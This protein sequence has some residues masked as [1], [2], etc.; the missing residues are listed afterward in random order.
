MA[1]EVGSLY[2][3][4]D[5]NDEKLGK[6]L[7]ASDKKVASFGSRLGQLGGQIQQGMKDAAKGLAVV[8]AGL[9]AYAKTATDYT[10]DLVKSSTALGRQLGVS[11]M[12]ASRLVAALGKMGISA[13][14]ASSMFGIFQ[15]NIA[16]STEK[17]AENRLAT[18]KLNIE[19]AKTKATIKLTTEEI[20]DNGDKTGALALKLRDLNNTLA[21]QQNALKSSADGFAKLGISTVDAKGKQKDFSAI[22][23]E[24]ADKFKEM[25]NGIDKTA[26]SMELFGR[27]GKDMVKVLNLGSKGIQDLEAAADKL[28]LT[29]TADTIGKV[30]ELVASQ[31]KLK[32]QT[33]AMKISVGTATAPVLTEFNT[34]LN[35]MVTQLL[36]SSEPMKSLT[37]NILAFGGPVS[38][39][40]AAVLGLL[41]NISALTKGVVMLLLRLTLVV[42]V[43]AL[44]GFAL[45]ELVQH[46]G[47]LNNVMNQ[48]MPTVNMVWGAIV[49]LATAIGGFLW[50]MIKFVGEAIMRDLWPALQQ[51]WSAFV[52]LWAAINPAATYILGG[53]AVIIGSVLLAA[54]YGIIGVIGILVHVFSGLIQIVT[55]VIQWLGYLITFMGNLAMIGWNT[56]NQL[57]GAFGKLPSFMQFVAAA[58]PAPFK[59][60][61]NAIASLWNATMG[62]LNFN[63]PGWVPGIGGKGFTLPKIPLLAK[64]GVTTGPTAAMIGEAGTEAVLPLSEL[65]KYSDLFSRIEKAAGLADGVQSGNTYQIGNVN[66]TTAEAVDEFFSIGNR[67]TQ[68]EMLG[69]SPLAGTAGA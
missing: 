61:F 32:E 24:V 39:A 38:G 51:L 66:L 48:V 37:T 20:R 28:G 40:A 33:D 25:P 22:L 1:Q 17:N 9:T 6:T 54:I 50:P 7:D 63:V 21:T 19:I 23:F 58:I 16:N 10:V 35:E 11:T 36:N 62:K 14:D 44:V 68:L 65:N 49:Q 59:A 53:L 30:Q 45:Y 12:E 43:F 18:E 60:A 41:A 42:A 4:L 29:L 57:I 31:K 26:L 55:G 5:I 34:R 2:Y 27:S 64:G 52:A 15:K 69:G 56:A 46:F 8:G 13:E 67:N 47:G 3:D